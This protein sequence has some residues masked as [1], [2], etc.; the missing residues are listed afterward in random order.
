M[1][2]L[3]TGG[4]ASGKS[5][6]AQG[7]ADKMKKEESTVVLDCVAETLAEKIRT[8]QSEVLPQQQIVEEIISEIRQLGKQTDNL[9]VVTNEVFSDVPGTEDQKKFA[10]CLGRINQVLAGEADLFVEV[11]YGIPIWRKQMEEKKGWW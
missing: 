9:I 4:S 5:W 8:C 2:M 1:F 6:I 7:F 11:V 3:V 10:E